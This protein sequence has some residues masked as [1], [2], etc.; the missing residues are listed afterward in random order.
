MKKSKTTSETSIDLSKWICNIKYQSDYGEW[1]VSSWKINFDGYWIDSRHIET[2][3]KLGYK[4]VTLE[5]LRDL[6]MVLEL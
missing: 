5:E 4:K 1:T 2:L 6:I 3:I